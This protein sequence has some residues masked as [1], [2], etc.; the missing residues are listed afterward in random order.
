MWSDAAALQS[1]LPRIEHTIEQGVNA[2][3][4]SRGKKKKATDKKPV[5]VVKQLAV[6]QKY[7]FY[8]Y[9][10]TPVNVIRVKLYDPRKLPRVLAVLQSGVVLQTAFQAYEAHV[11]YLLQFFMDHNLYGMGFMH[12]AHAKVCAL[13]LLVD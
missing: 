3:A 5:K 6:V 11:P 2:L 9:H 4:S 13:F 10:P 12:L 1:L 8:G 7:L